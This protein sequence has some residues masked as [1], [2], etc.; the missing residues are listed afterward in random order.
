M[1]PAVLI[2]D[3]ATAA[4]DAESE[5]AVQQALRSLSRG[6]TTFIVAHRLNTVRDADRILVVDGGRVVGDGTHESLLASCPT[7]AT[8][9][10]HQLGD[11]FRAV[12]APPVAAPVA[13]R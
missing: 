10:R 3:E 9:V 12:E 7:Y 4:L 6:R 1:N 8:L 2:F 13:A 11:D 5:L